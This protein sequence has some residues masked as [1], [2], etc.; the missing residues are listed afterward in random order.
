MTLRLARRHLRDDGKL[1]AGGRPRP[2]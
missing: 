1:L 2:I